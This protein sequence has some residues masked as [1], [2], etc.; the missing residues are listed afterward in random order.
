MSIAE[1]HSAEH[2]SAN[3]HSEEGHSV[4]PHST[5]F[6]SAECLSPLRYSEAVF[7]VVCDPSMN[8]L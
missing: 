7:L 6:H 4:D 1:W 8:E 2:H 3:C 5:Q